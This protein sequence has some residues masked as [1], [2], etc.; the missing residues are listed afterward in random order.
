MDSFINSIIGIQV[1]K[2]VISKCSTTDEM[3]ATMEKL[4][5]K[6]FI[7]TKTNFI[8]F[9]G[10]LLLAAFINLVAM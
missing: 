7:S 4:H 3:Q 2:R 9:I 8:C 5:E 1:A 6:A 10:A